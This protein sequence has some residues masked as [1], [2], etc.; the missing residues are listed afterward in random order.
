MKDIYK[1][2]I[3]YYVLVPIMAALWPL[4]VWAVYIPKAEGKWE[5]EK[6]QYD[7]AQ[8]IME[9]IL[10][11]DPGRLDFAD[12]KS[13]AAEFEYYV[14]VD[15]IASQ[16]KISATN[17]KLST[18]DIITSSGGQKTRTANIGMDKIDIARFAR[19]LSTIQLHWANL[20]CES[21]KLTKQKGHPDAW[22][23]DLKFK[24]YY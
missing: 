3:F 1:N 12:S 9:K 22:K 24:Y 18:R 8:K 2:P 13:G 14:A 15:K 21:V 11:L 6:K 16:H 5:K 4:L 17:Y 10:T 23:A 7:G 20:Q 19:F